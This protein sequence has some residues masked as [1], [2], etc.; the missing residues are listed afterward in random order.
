VLEVGATG[1]I[2]IQTSLPEGLQHVV[3]A[4]H[5]PA[6]GEYVALLNLAVALADDF[7]ESPVVLA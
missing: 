2:E 6:T 3:A 5:G 7:H 1:E 4:G